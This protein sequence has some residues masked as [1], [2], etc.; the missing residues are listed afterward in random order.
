[1]QSHQSSGS[2]GPKS[3][4]GSSL[5]T[6]NAHQLQPPQTSTQSPATLQP[7]VSHQ[8]SPG[9]SQGTNLVSSQGQSGDSTPPISQPT[10]P[11]AHAPIAPLPL[12]PQR[13]PPSTSSPSSARIPTPTLVTPTPQASTSAL[14]QS[15]GAP[16]RHASTVYLTQGRTRFPGAAP[17]PFLVN[18]YG[19][20]HA[21]HIPL[22]ATTSHGDPFQTSYGVASTS[23][24]IQALNPSFPS[25]SSLTS[26]D[27]S[28]D[29]VRAQLA[30]LVCLPSETPTAEETWASYASNCPS[31]VRRLAEEVDFI[32][33]ELGKGLRGHPTIHV[34]ATAIRHVE[35]TNSLPQALNR[36]GK[37]A[38][39]AT[40]RFL[41]KFRVLSYYL[42]AVGALR[43]PS[44]PKPIGKDWAI[45]VPKT[46]LQQVLIP[47]CD[48]WTTT[49]ER[50]RQKLAAVKPVV[51]L[52]IPLRSDGTMNDR[53]AKFTLAMKAAGETGGAFTLV[54]NIYGCVLGLMQEVLQPTLRDT[55]NPVSTQIAA[56][57]PRSSAGTRAESAQVPNSSS[58]LSAMITPITVAANTRLDTRT[59][60]PEWL[61]QGSF[62]IGND[63]PSELAGA[64]AQ[65][66]KL[67]VDMGI[68]QIDVFP[69]FRAMRTALEQLSVAPRVADSMWFSPPRLLPA[70]PNRPPL[71]RARSLGLEQLHPEE[72]QHYPPSKKTRR[73]LPHNS[74][75]TSTGLPPLILPATDPQAMDVD[76]TDDETHPPTT[77]NPHELP[78]VPQRLQYMSPLS[79]LPE[80]P[81]DHEP[82]PTDKGKED[83]RIARETREQEERIAKE[84]EEEASRIAKDKE[85]EERLAREKQAEE[86]R[87]ARQKQL[88]LA[89]EKEKEAKRLEKEKEK[90]AKRL[91]KEKEK[92]A[93][94]LEKEKEKEARRLEKQKENTKDLKGKNKLPPGGDDDDDEYLPSPR[95]NNKEHPSPSQ[96]LTWSL[97]VNGKSLLL[98]DESSDEEGESDPWEEVD[99]VH[100]RLLI[101]AVTRKFP[102]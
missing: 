9:S 60:S 95:K 2:H 93:R 89:K 20:T 25:P 67:V 29:E 83:D 10:R 5:E 39:D 73:V 68:G 32:E 13:S 99:P 81:S 37:I 1:M 94:R 21:L 46:V 87:V 61:I 47:V 40:L 85:A 27:L 6:T 71:K 65:L 41:L 44:R 53:I 22:F 14:V 38:T 74:G 58:R 100:A 84:K 70:I 8:S 54:E 34:L 42:L 33:G 48:D 16:S 18:P 91:E 66:M 69:A 76:P 28:L 63:H 97:Q 45:S 30:K 59:T 62:D 88:A 78:N 101:K 36:L 75:T 90:E 43:R 17:P 102:T 11:S 52:P 35:E 82:I 49:L 7:H 57:P 50:A 55:S 23:T 24:P 19:H 72:A 31:E 86:E 80:D 51:D 98:R 56:P 96:S 26:S 79:D 64:Q 12:S 77:P 3:S 92:E 4:P 15:P